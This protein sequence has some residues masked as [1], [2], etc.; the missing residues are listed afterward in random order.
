ML[1]FIALFPSLLAQLGFMRGVQL[2]GPGRAGLFANLAPVFGALLAILILG[3][4]FK[5]F[6]LGA[7]LLVVGGILVA[8]T[9]G[10]LRPGDSRISKR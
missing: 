1:L 3:E 7:L 6:H 4:P 8:E 9:A 2:I 10:R 5:L